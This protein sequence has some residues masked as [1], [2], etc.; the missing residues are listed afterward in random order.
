ME[1]LRDWQK[2][3]RTQEIYNMLQLKRTNSN[4]KDFQL[5]ANQLDKDLA[6]RYGTLQAEY[7][8]YNI[9]EDLHTI[10]VAYIDKKPVGCGCFKYFDKN[11]VEVK[12][13]FVDGGQRGN[14]IGAAI[15]TELEKWAR[16]LDYKNMILE[17]GTAQPEAIHL[18]LK[19]GYKVIPNYEPYI[20]NE[21][22]SI[23]MKKII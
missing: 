7:D 15:L 2:A 21:E 19:Q 17:T 12:R 13:M 3:G 11:T 14:G 20:G 23:C 4:D 16:E 18:Y 22:F 10:I 9:V 5:L 1:P 8:Q 6:I